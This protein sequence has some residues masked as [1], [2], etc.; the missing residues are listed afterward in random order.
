MNNYGGR[1][2]T[3]LE[4]LQ[5]LKDMSTPVTP[6]QSYLVKQMQTRIAACLA[7]FI[8]DVSRSAWW[9]DRPW[10]KPMDVLW[11][12]V[13]WR[14]DNQYFKFRKQAG[15]GP[16]PFAKVTFSNV[17]WD[18][19]RSKLNYGRKRV[20]Q[21]VQ[22]ESNSK[23]KIIKNDTSS[24]IKVNYD[25]E[26]SVTD[27][28]S[29]S[30]TKG[31]TMDMSASSETTISGGYAGVSVE[32]KL[33]ATFGVSKSREETHDKSVE[34]TRSEGLS[35]EFDAKAGLYYL[36][37]I[38]KEHETTYQDFDIDGVQDFASLIEMPWEGVKRDLHRYPGHKLQ[39]NSIDDLEQLVHGYDTDYPYMEGYWDKAY[40]RVRN[41]LDYIFDPDHRRIIVSGTNQANLE[42]NVDYH[43]EE[44]GNNL[45]PEYSHL[46]VE[47]ADK[48]AA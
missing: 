1:A 41:A 11:Y 40:S 12:P 3:N 16:G 31:L 17:R 21:D 30:I 29:T 5:S 39:L 44:L 8:H 25:E 13:G 35:I 23:T 15:G 47:S 27:S 26:E 42:K 48:L 4:S 20:A 7:P 10:E 2:M 18:P 32:E 19:L 24:L 33:T 45:P 34:G 38:T 14:K 6:N 36:V 9:V 43:V 22:L 37:T 46:P 28:F